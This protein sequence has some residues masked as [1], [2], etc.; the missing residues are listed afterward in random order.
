MSKRKVPSGEDNPNHDFC[1][2]LT[3]NFVSD[4]LKILNFLFQS[5]LSMKKMLQEIFTGTMPTEK[6][7]LSY[8]VILQELNQE[9]KQKN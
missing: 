6:L 3:G 2:F 9:M 1:E 8:Q 4:L 5:L 7:P